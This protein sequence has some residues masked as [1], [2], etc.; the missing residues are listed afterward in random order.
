MKNWKTTTL[1][2]LAIA[3]VIIHVAT[4]LLN[5]QTPTMADLSA[6]GAALTA[7]WGLIHA[8]D[9]SAAPGAK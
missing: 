1:G 6:D 7:G 4:G 3:G 8:A 9:A 2:C 5:G